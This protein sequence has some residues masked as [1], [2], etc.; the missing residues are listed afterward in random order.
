MGC[1]QGTEQSGK[2]KKGDFIKP[3]AIIQIKTGGG[4]HVDALHHHNHEADTKH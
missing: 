4:H 3:P 1:A 2:K